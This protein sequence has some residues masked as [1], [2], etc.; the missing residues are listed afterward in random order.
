MSWKWR[1][2][3]L[4]PVAGAMPV[5]ERDIE[6]ASA[7]KGAVGSAGRNVIAVIGIDHYHHWQRLSNAVRDATGA[8][9]LF[10]RLGFEEVT[11]PLL[12]ERATGKAIQSLVTDDLIALGPDD[13]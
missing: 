6:V 7:S 8:A 3:R 11:A 9:S 2:R 13:S 4:M 10:R 5:S 1:E 12:D